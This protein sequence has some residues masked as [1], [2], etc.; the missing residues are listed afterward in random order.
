[1]FFCGDHEKGI[2]EQAVAF[3]CLDWDEEIIPHGWSTVAFKGGKAIAKYIQSRKTGIAQT[4]LGKGCVYSFGFQY[5]YAYC[6]RM[7]PIVP[8]Q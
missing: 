1:M 2:R 5:G 4:K 8:S 6:R 7:M 3:D